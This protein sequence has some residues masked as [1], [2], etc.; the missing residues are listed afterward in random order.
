MLDKLVKLEKLTITPLDP[1]TNNPISGS[2]FKCLFNPNKFS[3]DYAIDYRCSEIPNKSE[4][5]FSSRINPELALELILDG[6]GVNQMGISAIFGT[7]T[8]KQQLDQ[9]LKIAFEFNSSK[10]E[11]N[12]LQITWGKAL[13]F[14]GRLKSA[15]VD[16]ELFD[17][18]GE[19]LRAKL[20]VA[21]VEH[22]LRSKALKTWKFN[23]P[24]LTH[25]KLVNSDENLPLKTYGIYQDS[26]YYL[27][28]ARVNKLNNFRRLQVGTQLIFPPIEQ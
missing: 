3:M 1:N 13:T 27:E 5:E 26:R 14:K 9:F 12:A 24:D 7:K 25:I 10:H 23:S 11:P 4:K 21:F 20:N 6:T 17:K 22:E 2:K 19:P 16:Y 18:D 15:K 28:V 8:V